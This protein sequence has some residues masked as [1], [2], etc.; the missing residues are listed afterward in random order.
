MQ[1][2]TGI[3][4]RACTPLRAASA[5]TRT[6]ENWA[7][8]HQRRGFTLLEMV[9][10]LGIIAILAA[11][12]LPAFIAR[13]DL[14]TRNQEKVY[15]T[16]ISNSLALNVLRSNN[17]PSEMTWNACAAEW[18]MIPMSKVNTN[19]RRYQRIYYSLNTPNP[20]LPYT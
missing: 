8:M 11:A 16:G 13:I 5:G 6:P 4:G 14:A 10:V 20:T 9:G 19:S 15:L 17:V 18:S 2:I 3:K 1:M 12:L 7:N